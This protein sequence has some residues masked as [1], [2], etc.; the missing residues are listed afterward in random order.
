MYLGRIML[1]VL[2]QGSPLKSVSGV[3][4]LSVE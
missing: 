1:H 2:T 4:E 3:L